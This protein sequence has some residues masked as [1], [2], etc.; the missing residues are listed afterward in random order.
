[1]TVRI[2]ERKHEFLQETHVSTCLE[3]L[4][5]KHYS[6]KE[7]REKAGTATASLE[8][9]SGKQNKAGLSGYS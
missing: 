5:N 2:S 6:R 8:A 7:P 1:M 3:L 4:T 9:T